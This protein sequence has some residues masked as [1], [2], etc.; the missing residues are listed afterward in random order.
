MCVVQVPD[1]YQ[2]DWDVAIIRLTKS[3]GNS[4]TGY[5]GLAQGCAINPKTK[6]PTSSY[7]VQ[8]AGYA[9]D[10]A[11]GTCTTMT[12]S[13]MRDD[14]KSRTAYHNCTSKNGLSGSPFFLPKTYRIRGILVGTVSI[15]ESELRVAHVVGTSTYAAVMKWIT[16]PGDVAISDDAKSGDTTVRGQT[17]VQTGN[18][19]GTGILDAGASFID[20]A[21]QGTMDVLFG[22]GTGS[23]DAKKPSAKPAPKPAPKPSPKPSPKSPAKTPPKSS[24]GLLG[25]VLGSATDAAQAFVGG[26]TPA[27]SPPPKQLVK[28]IPPSPKKTG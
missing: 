25:S 24:G 26:K 13:L 6:R 17:T 19:A 11:R 4:V 18:K 27:R 10:D 2:Y 3:I 21:I 14:C 23:R 20:G 9:T 28:R 1:L 5:L 7:S 22:G 16:E 12:C 15:E 8:T